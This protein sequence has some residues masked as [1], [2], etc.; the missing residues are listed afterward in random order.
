MSLRRIA[1]FLMKRPWL[2]VLIVVL[3]NFI[4]RIIHADT[5]SIYIDEG[6]TMFQ[7]K[8]SLTEIIEEYVKKQQN[9]PLY[10]VVL[11]FWVKIFGLS[12][13]SVRAFS[14][15]M[16]SLTSGVFFLLG[17]KLINLE[18]AIASSLFF[19][20]VSDIMNY[21]HEARGYAT[22]SFFTVSSFYLLL[23]L[24]KKPRLLPAALL[25]AANTALLYTH[26]LTI[27]VFPAQAIVAL[28]WFLT[29]KDKKALLYYT[30]SQVA[31][32]LV[33]LPW[34]NVVFDVMPEEGSF[35]IPEPTWNLLKNTYYYLIPGR[36]RTHVTFAFLL[37]S[38]LWYVVKQILGKTNKTAEVVIVLCF[39]LWAFLPVM[40]NYF[41][42]FHV[43]V[44]TR[45]YTFY[46]T[47][48][49]ILFF[50]WAVFNLPVGKW[51][52]WGIILFCS[53]LVFTKLK[54]TSP[55]T[56]NWKAA[57]EYVKEHKTDETLVFTQ[58]HYVF[59][60][61]LPYYD[62]EAFRDH[63]QPYAA[64]EDELIYFRSSKEPL[65]N[66]INK[67]HPEKVILIRSHWKGDDP[68]GEVKQYLDEHWFLVADSPKFSGVQVYIYEPPNSS[69]GEAGS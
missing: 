61:F 63:P 24:L 56:E 64:C 66:L 34:L 31:V 53:V 23:D 41:V 26:Y 51:F 54:W 25:F 7:V 47:F 46:A 15:L 4:M 16:M 69:Q 37:I 8:R 6:Q 49:F 57:V 29:K 39:F 27:Y 50:T 33:F 10:F 35:W 17:R 62:F 1:E 58:A 67:F 18:F 22:L 14:V 45:K 9:A 20:G 38:L 30:L 48:G 13:F 43:P 2:L 60:G 28:V 12:I 19:L 5:S 11:H 3:V 36:A 55:K 68:K 21:A 44:F 65:I 52:R 42:G 59:R 40:A 32:V